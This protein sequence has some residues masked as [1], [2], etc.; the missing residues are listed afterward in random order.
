MP[1]M[2]TSMPAASLSE[3]LRSSCANRYGGIWYRRLLD[4]MQLLDE[5]IGER[6]GEDRHR[7]AA[8]GNAEV[9]LHLDLQLSAVEDDRH[10]GFAA[11]QHMGPRRSG[12]PGPAGRGLA[13]PALED[14]CPDAMRLEHRVP[15]DVGAMGKQLV[16]LDRAPDRGQVQR[17]PRGEG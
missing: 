11:R 5:V 14:P 3:I 10:R 2:I 15:G 12:R 6:A 4:L 7:P 17:L 1:R 13:D 9:L 16:M 8:Q